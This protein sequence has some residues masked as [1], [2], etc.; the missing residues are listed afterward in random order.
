MNDKLQL[1]NYEKSDCLSVN[2]TFNPTEVNARMVQLDKPI[3][4]LDSYVLMR[5]EIAVE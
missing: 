3:L 4:I 5:K 1:K 2:L